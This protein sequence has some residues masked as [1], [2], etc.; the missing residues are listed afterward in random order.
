VRP[1]RPYRPYRPTY[2]PFALL[3]TYDPNT[4]APSQAFV[5][6][7]QGISRITALTT[8]LVMQASHM[9]TCTWHKTVEKTTF[10]GS[11]DEHSW[12]IL[13]R[14]RSSCTRGYSPPGVVVRLSA[15]RGS[16]SCVQV[17]ENI[18]THATWG[19]RGI[20][21]SDVV[22]CMHMSICLCNVPQISSALLGKEQLNIKRGQFSAATGPP[23][24]AQ[25][26]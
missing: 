19:F 4:S 23:T 7:F 1:Y 22:T 3:F 12:E 10:L 2:R 14:G 17:L 8:H 24:G 18:H 20:F 11:R 6:T 9:R 16:F 26:A 21:S 15:K 25:G 5:E 13:S